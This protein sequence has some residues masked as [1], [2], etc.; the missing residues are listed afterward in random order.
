[1][2]HVDQPALFLLHQV[3]PGLRHLHPALLLLLPEQP[4]QH[5]LHV[6]VHLFDAGAGDDLEGREAPLPHLHFH[7]LLVQP[8]FPQL[9]PQALPGL[10]EV[11]L[12]GA[13]LDRRGGGVR[14]GRQ[15]QVEQALFG[16]HFRPLG[17]FLQLLLP[18]HFDGH[19]Q[20]VA[21]HR[22]HVPAH[23]ADLGVLRSLHLQEGRV[24]QPGQPPGDLGL[25]HSGGADHQDVLG[26]DFLRQLGRELSPPD[27]VPQGNGHG[28][29]GRLLAD[30]VLVQ[31]GHDL[32]R[33]QLIGPRPQREL[34]FHHAGK[35]N[36]HRKCPKENLSRLPT[37]TC[38]YNTQLVPFQLAEPTV[39]PC[40]LF[41]GIGRGSYA[42]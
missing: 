26:Q 29:L 16:V 2:L 31:L 35:L 36:G 6:D 21:D 39:P 28:A 14:Q 32:P 24:G 7:H 38:D 19:V 42:A 5:V 17:H 25:P 1:M 37:T 40:Q 10:L 18:H 13:R 12:A 3:V 27:A 20:Q 23:V 11:L 15:Q 4:R 34:L 33:R 9:G 30:D 8:P 41:F 22:F